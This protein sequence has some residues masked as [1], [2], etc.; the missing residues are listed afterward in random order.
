MNSDVLAALGGVGLFLIGMQMLSGGL[1]ALAGDK[2]RALLARFTRTPLSGAV[3]GAAVTA[4]I[5]SSS[6]TTV[7]AIG[8]VS[9]GLLTFS[10]ALG[11]IFG[12]N[13]GTTITGWLVAILG[14][15]LDLGQTVLPL[16]LVGA[17]LQLLGRGGW[18][19]FGQALAGF[20]LLFIGIDA[21]KD[22]LEAFEGVVTPR[23][24]PEDTVWGRLQLVGIGVLITLVTQSSSAGVATALAAL[25]AGAISFPQAAA[26]V[27]GMDVGTTFTALL[28]TVGGSTMTRRTGVA[29]VI[30]NLMTGVMAFLLL[31]V[32]SALFLRAS[33]DP[34]I[35]LV[36]F[37]SAFNF[38]GVVLVLPFATPFA[39][40]IERI[41]PASGAA[42]TRRLDSAALAVPT[43]AVRAAADTVEVMARTLARHVAAG[44]GD[45]AA[46]RADSGWRSED[47]DTALL[48]TRN[49]LREIHARDL[50][51]GEIDLEEA[52]FHV[53]DHLRR[54]HFRCGQIGRLK[55]IRETRELRPYGQELAKLSQGLAES[56]ASEAMTQEFDGYRRRLREVR[57]SL[58]GTLVE[59]AASGKIGHEEAAARMDALRWLHRSG[60]HLWRIALHLAETRSD[61]TPDTV[62]EPPSAEAAAGPV[63]QS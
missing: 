3:T 41:V 8:F 38:L 2:L 61:E 26:L 7:T 51:E 25:G 5:Q 42:M 4:L 36:A 60:Y 13:I 46:A 32:A 48:E 1:R 54:L 56:G 45:A 40:L 9:A 29:H 19:R 14:F 35:A 30:Y 22:G 37:H 52:S 34:Q 49:Y 17:L 12:A 15:K 6:A 28:A 59:Q 63:V 62:P 44:L 23:D 31:P 11:I 33:P 21:M 24:F 50:A 20:S 18:A 47:F 58:R 57:R 16:V 10:H 55:V 27:I 39:R 43:L 53:L